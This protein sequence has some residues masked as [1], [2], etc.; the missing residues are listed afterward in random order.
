MEVTQNKAFNELK[1]NINNKQDTTN[2]TSQ[3]KK[4]P[5]VDRIDSCDT[6]SWSNTLESERP[7]YQ[8]L[9]QN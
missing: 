3:N 9:I 2:L 8:N 6:S 7:A 5:D 4:M 1:Q